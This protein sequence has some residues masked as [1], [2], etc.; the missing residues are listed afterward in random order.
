MSGIEKGTT[1][2][3][4]CVKNRQEVNKTKKQCRFDRSRVLQARA[5]SNKIFSLNGRRKSAMKNHK[6]I[7]SPLLSEIIFYYR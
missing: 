1:N 7:T 5:V 2:C 3:P 4:E 6:I